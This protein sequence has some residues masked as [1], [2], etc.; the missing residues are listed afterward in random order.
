MKGGLGWVR[1]LWFRPTCRAEAE[2]STLVWAGGEGLGMHGSTKRL[3]DYKRGCA[4]MT[5]RGGT[6]P[7]T[8]ADLVDY[9]A[10]HRIIG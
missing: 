3:V 1:V 4:A 6:W 2:Q 8:P 7:C 10:V 9:D 5:G